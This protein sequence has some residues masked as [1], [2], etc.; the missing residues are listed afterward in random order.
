[1]PTA[2]GVLDGQAE[3]AIAFAAA[4]PATPAAPAL[5]FPEAAPPRSEAYYGLKRALDLLMGGLAFVLSLPVMLVLAVIVRLDS[6]GPI[7]FRQRRVGEG[8]QL[9]TFYKFRTMWVDARERFPHLYAYQYS[10]EEIRTM[11]FKVLD[12]PRLTRF[13]RHLRKT[14]LD[15]LPNLLNV[16][17]GDMSLVG[18]RPELPEMVRYY[19]GAQTMK[20]AVRP[21]VTGLAQVTGR[22]VLPFQEAISA[23][24]TYC[25]ERSLSL[26][27]QIL[28]RTAKTVALRVGA[29]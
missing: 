18:P 29:F 26:D 11:Y 9:F 15:E 8:G 19:T 22:A 3:T 5:F 13:G 16:L 2:V 1:L 10:D 24:L 4:A 7:V 20:F 25:R 21:G 14:S 28:V 6:P 27:L 17:R 23:D 12:D